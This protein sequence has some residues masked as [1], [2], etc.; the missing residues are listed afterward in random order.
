MIADA[1]GLLLCQFLIVH[2]MDENLGHSLSLIMVTSL[3][4]SGLLVFLRHPFQFRQ[5][6]AQHGHEADASTDEI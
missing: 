3:Q 6:G 2:G 1:K 5:Y 4:A